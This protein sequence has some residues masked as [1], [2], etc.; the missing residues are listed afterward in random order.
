MA[1]LQ[2]FPDQKQSLL[3]NPDLIHTAVDEFLRF[4]SPNQFGNRLTTCAVE[5]G[6]TAVPAGTNLH[7]CIGAANRD[8]AVFADPHRLDLA[9][10]P[11]RHLAFAGGPHLCVGFQ[12]ARLEGRIAISRFLKRYP[13]YRLL[14]GARLEG[15]IRFRGYAA[16]PAA[17]STTAGSAGAIPGTGTAA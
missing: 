7:L 5:I 4:L 8:P 3:D 9:R 15:R 16:L 13:D 10:K 1:A 17:L 12:L 14:D 6:G 11:N 2:A